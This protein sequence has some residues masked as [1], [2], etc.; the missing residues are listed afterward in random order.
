VL[1]NA[2]HLA[3]YL[4]GTEISLEANLPLGIL[5]AITYSQSTF[6]LP[7]AARLTLLSDGV[8]EARSRTGELFGFDRTSEVSQLSASEIATKA[9]HFGHQDDITVITLDW[10]C[11]VRSL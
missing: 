4:N 2:G 10:P 11:G 7:T 6:I 5:P 1:A 9:H 8:V 3:P